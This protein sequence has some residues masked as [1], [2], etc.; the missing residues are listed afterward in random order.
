[1]DPALLD[2]A[3]ALTREGR[4]P[5]EA[6]EELGGK[7]SWRTIYRAQQRAAASVAPTVQEPAA[8]TPAA[9]SAVE[10]EASEAELGEADANARKLDVAIAGSRT[11]RRMQATLS[12]ALAVHPDAARD[13][14]RALREVT[15]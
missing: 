6:A 1:M 7:L 10:P 4:S 2:R 11:W 14:A 9:G 13:V 12:R 5:R 8:A 3:L 15:L